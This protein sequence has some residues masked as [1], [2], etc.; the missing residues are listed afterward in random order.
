MKAN[1]NQRVEANKLPP[2]VYRLFSITHSIE[3]LPELHLIGYETFPSAVLIAKINRPIKIVIKNCPRAGDAFV[4]S[5][6][7]AAASNIKNPAKPNNLK[8]L[9]VSIT[10]K[11]INIENTKQMIK[12]KNLIDLKIIFNEFGCTYSLKAR[13][14]N[15]PKISNV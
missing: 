13:T 10:M 11:V 4:K 15:K 9:P 8:S 3:N 12:I 5:I 1:K 14:I 2:V 7:S 6:H